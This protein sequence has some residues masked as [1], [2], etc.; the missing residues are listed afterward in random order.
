MRRDTSSKAYRSHAASSIE[1]SSIR[2]RI[3]VRR[4]AA[5]A[6]SEPG[7]LTTSLHPR[8]TRFE[9]CQTRTLR[10]GHAGKRRGGELWRSVGDF[11]R[12][13]GRGVHRCVRGGE[14]NRQF[15]STG[16]VRG[17]HVLDIVARLPLEPRR[18]LYVVEVAGKTLLVGTSEM[19]LSLLTELDGAAVRART[20]VRQNFGDLVRTAWLNRRGTPPPDDAAIATPAIDARGV[21]QSDAAADP[22]APSAP[23]V[24]MPVHANRPADSAV[25]VARDRSAS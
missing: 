23:G 21:A 10:R 22:A 6:R 5:S 7:L 14:A 25:D 20:P 17:A 18:S 16:R 2:R 11:P 15:L 3:G 19:G 1:A 4:A 13:A 24:V 12:G 9:D 8:S